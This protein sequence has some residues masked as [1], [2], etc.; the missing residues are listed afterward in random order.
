MMKALTSD[1]WNTIISDKNYT[2]QRVRCLAEN[3]HQLKISRSYDEIREAYL[4]SHKYAHEIWREENYRSLPAVERLNYILERLSTE[5]TV[6]LRRRVLKKFEEFVISDPPLLIE[7]VRK[8]LEFL[9]L[10]CK[11]G[12][13]SDTGMTPGEVLRRVLTN[14]QILSFFEVTVFSDEIGYNKPHKNMFETALKKLEVNPSEAIHIGDLLQ[15]DIA[16]AKAIGMKAIWFNKKGTANCGPYK[17]DYEIRRFPE[18]ID[19]LNGIQVL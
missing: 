14:H 11:M 2:D 19:I 16:G 6:N 1:L 12:I 18:L 5:L 17:P 4:A 8:T 10:K 3:L 15:T 7:G 9:S 13:I